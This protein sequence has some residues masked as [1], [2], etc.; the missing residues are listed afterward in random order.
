MGEWHNVDPNTRST[1]RYMISRSDDSLTV[2]GYGS[3]T[4]TD[5]NWA[6]SVGGPRTIST[7]DANT[8]QFTIAWPFDFKTQTDLIELLPDG[9]VKV[10]STHEYTDDR[11]DRQETQFFTKISS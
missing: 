4:P 8:G 6:Q 11:A 5:C 1:T 9:R 10:S 2:E 7:S 3:C